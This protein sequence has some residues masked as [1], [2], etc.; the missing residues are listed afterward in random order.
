ML[1]NGMHT[2]ED[3]VLGAHADGPAQDLAG[4]CNVATADLELCQQQPH[5]GEGEPAVSASAQGMSSDR[6]LLVELKK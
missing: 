3:L 5:L 2:S 6:K 1:T 4:G